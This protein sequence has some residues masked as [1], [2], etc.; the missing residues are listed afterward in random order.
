MCVF[1]GDWYNSRYARTSAAGAVGAL[2]TA[3]GLSGN[4]ASGVWCAAPELRQAA[5]GRGEHYQSGSANYLVHKTQVRRAY[6]QIKAL[7]TSVDD[8]SY[9][10]RRDR[11]RGEVD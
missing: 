1:S 2:G 10:R 3:V 4:S 8:C 6:Y 5:R 11:R 9:P 7:Q